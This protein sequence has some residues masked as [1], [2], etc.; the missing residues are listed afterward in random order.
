MLARFLTPDGHPQE[1]GLGGVYFLGRA[2]YDLLDRL[3]ELISLEV[4]DHRVVPFQYA[5][6]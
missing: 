2:G 5:L 1:R 6:A 4:P 3:L